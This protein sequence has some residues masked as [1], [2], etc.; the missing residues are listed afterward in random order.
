MQAIYV[1]LTI[2]MHCVMCP[3]CSVQGQL[4]S[5]ILSLVDVNGTALYVILTI[6]DD[7][8]LILAKF[9][10]VFLQLLMVAKITVSVYSFID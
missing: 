1:L 2:A 9:S 5:L 7:A 4:H 8:S 10:T 6:G 3:S